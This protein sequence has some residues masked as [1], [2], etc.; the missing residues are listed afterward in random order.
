MSNDPVFS[1]YKIPVSHIFE[2][3]RY[4]CSSSGLPVLNMTGCNKAAQG[5][6]VRSNRILLLTVT[7]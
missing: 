7:V 2:V 5:V 6:L 4:I 3:S 1:T